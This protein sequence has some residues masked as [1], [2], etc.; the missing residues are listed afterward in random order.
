MKINSLFVSI[1]FSALSWISVAQ[2]GVKT[3]EFELNPPSAEDGGGTFVFSF[4]SEKTEWIPNRRILNSQDPSEAL[5]SQQQVQKAVADELSFSMMGEVD[6]RKSLIMVL[7][8]SEIKSILSTGHLPEK[9]AEKIPQRL[10]RDCYYV[11]KD[12]TNHSFYVFR[13]KDNSPK[14]AWQKIDFICVLNG[15]SWKD[16]PDLSALLDEPKSPLELDMKSIDFLIRGGVLNLAEGK[17]KEVA[18]DSKD[19]KGFYPAAAKE[20]DILFFFSG[21]S[22]VHPNESPFKNALLKAGCDYFDG[23]EEYP[24]EGDTLLLILNKRCTVIMDDEIESLCSQPAKLVGN[25]YGVPMDKNATEQ[26]MVLLETSAKKLYLLIGLDLENKEKYLYLSIPRDGISLEHAEAIQEYRSI[27]R[28]KQNADINRQKIFQT[29]DRKEAERIIVEERARQEQLNQQIESMN[30]KQI[31][32]TFP[33]TPEEIKLVEDL[34]VSA[35]YED[36]LK[37]CEGKKLD[38][39]V[40]GRHNLLYDS[41]EKYPKYRTQSF[42]ENKNKIIEYLLENGCRPALSTATGLNCMFY[43]II[44]NNKDAFFLLLKHGFDLNMTKDGKTVCD[45]VIDFLESDKIDSEIANKLR[46]SKLSLVSMVSLNDFDGVKKALQNIENQ[47]SINKKD[48]NGK[49]LIEYAIQLKQESN[50]DM[51]RLLLDAGALLDEAILDTIIFLKKNELLSVVWVFYRDRLTKEQWMEV[52]LSTVR[53]KNMDAF[54]FFLEQGFDPQEKN[55]NGKSAITSIYSSGPKEMVD[56]MDQRGIKKPF[57][58]AVRWNDLDLVKEYLA[59]GVDVNASSVSNSPPITIAAWNNYY[60]LAELLLQHGVY[61]SPEQYYNNNNLYPVATIANRDNSAN[62]MD[63]L[64][65]HGFVPDFPKTPGDTKHASESSALYMA[66]CGKQYE[67]A[68]ILL[69][70]GARTD[71]TQKQNVWDKSTQTVI[72]KDLGLNEIFQGDPEAMKVLGVK[73]GFF[74]FF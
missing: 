24:G 54:F 4:S 15:Q 17:I 7:S 18:A 42:L 73:K 3:V 60:E 36:L 16:N 49:V 39:N 71:V 44:T 45:Y 57:W 25:Y 58:A 2:A 50:I 48:E 29:W 11:L 43:A 27:Q 64:L 53:H 70:Y 66:L 23:V 21:R 65:K 61:V 56:I 37:L 20:G 14:Y 1:A 72:K 6:M 62:M 47:K 30:Q 63:L 51:V 8:E 9:E 19:L 12:V 34:I 46:E 35:K 69:K 67:T 74:S 28:R 10:K 59:A 68:K 41:I 26:P 33:K 52:F 38:F 55:K 31:G 32:D 13:L 40:E 22:S 5:F